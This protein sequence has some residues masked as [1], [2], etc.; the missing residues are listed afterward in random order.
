MVAV[1]SLVALTISGFGQDQEGAINWQTYE[2]GQT[3]KITEYKT[4]VIRNQ[5]QWA[6]YWRHAHGGV[7]PRPKGVDWRRNELLAIHL[8][9]RNTGGYSVYVGGVVPMAPRKYEVSVVAHEPPPGTMVTQALTSPYVVVKLPRNLGAY[10]ITRE[11]DKPDGS[12][13]DPRPRTPPL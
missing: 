5:K 8:G 2:T 4:F 13:P 7:P 9:Q 6:D 3:S 1:L 11:V 12:N 10:F